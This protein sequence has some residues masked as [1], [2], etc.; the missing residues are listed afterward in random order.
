MVRVK[1]FRFHL[2]QAAV[3]LGGALVAA[4]ARAI[5]PFVTDDARVVGHRLAQLETWLV[6]DR[7]V[8]E[9]NAFAAVGPTDWLEL[10]LGVTHGRDHAGPDRGYSITGPVL[11]GKA[12]IL[13]A[14]D[15]GRPGAAVAAGVIPPFGTG[16]FPPP[17]WGAFVYGA[18]TESL[19]DERLLIHANLGFAVGDEGSTAS[20]IGFTGGSRHNVRT[21]VT[22]GL[23]AQARVVAG[24][25]AV[26][27]FYY[28]D[29]YD[30]RTDFPAM[31]A[32]FRYVFNDHVQT[33]GTFGTTL[34]AVTDAGGH[35]QVEQWASMGV[36]LVTPEL[37]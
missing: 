27:E 28:G 14:V 6:L 1:S 9:H 23:G 17:G 33:D 31:Q 15:N 25:H 12:L 30:P 18:L 37:W 7:L 35:A 3:V 2:L 5:R 19:L 11:Q 36:R 21:L 34:M 13:P 22:V 16:A 32:G 8:L 29:P 26:T 20:S 10:T 4:P 24:L